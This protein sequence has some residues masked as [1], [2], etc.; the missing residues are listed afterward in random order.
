M[1][2]DR[3]SP[4]KSVKQTLIASSNMQAKFIT[5]Y[6]ATT[7]V[8][9]SRNFI[10][11]LKV[12]NSIFRPLK[13]YYDNSIVVMFSKNNKISNGSKHIKIKYHVVRYMI[14]NGDILI[15]HLNTK[16]M[17]A[18]PLTKALWP[19]VFKKQ[20]KNMNVVDSFDVLN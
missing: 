20:V 11:M 1:L 2:V 10:S 15:K 13:V 18:D 19:L 5:Y 9:W 7:N 6:G 4:W 14:K 3:A 12:A 16:S 17:I 8:M